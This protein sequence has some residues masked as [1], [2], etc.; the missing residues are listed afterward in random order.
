MIETENKTLFSEQVLASA[1]CFHVLK[2]FDERVVSVC[3]EWEGCSEY[4]LF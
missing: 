2:G 3:F 4:T 1:S